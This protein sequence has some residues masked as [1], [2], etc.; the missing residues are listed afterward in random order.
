[1]L[2]LDY[3]GGSVHMGD[4]NSDRLSGPGEFGLIRKL[5]S[6]L[7]RHHPSTRL[8]I[9]DDAA[10]LD[11]AGFNIVVTTDLLLEG[12]HFDLDYV[13]LRHLGYKSVIVNL[14]DICAMCAVPLQITVSLGISPDMGIHEVE[15]LYNGIR[16]ACNRYSVD[17]IGGDTSASRSGLTISI[18]ALGAARQGQ[19][20]YRK[21][22]RPG[23]LICVT[24]NLGAAYLGL[25]FLQRESRL[26][27]ENPDFSPNPDAY[28]YLVGRQLKPEAQ[29]DLVD[30]LLSR[31]IR[32]T[33]MIDLSD[34]LSSDLLHVCEASGTGS[35]I[36]CDKI[37]LHD[38]TV[39][40]SEE[41][42]ASPLVAAL[43][44]GEDYEI[45]FTAGQEDVKIISEIPG[46]TVIGSMTEGEAGNWLILPD[47]SIV[48][49]AAGGWDAFRVR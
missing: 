24:G 28:P 46:V 37:P 19:L 21:G 1:V 34:G 16:L 25:L 41:I 17:V 7:L 48:P 31:D 47:H 23:D 38:E 11:Y 35:R 32:P 30:H 43:N 10:V 33:A 20:V 14:S 42:Q 39:R 29:T 49:M 40:F 4:L 18:T 3:E 45:L 15:E 13:P 27:K 22:A 26:S 44:G 2:F 36:D 5:T 8:G 9:G 12:V 6:G